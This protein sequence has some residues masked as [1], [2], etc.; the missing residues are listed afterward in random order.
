MSPHEES[1]CNDLQDQF[2]SVYEQEYEING[3][4]VFGDLVNLLVERQEAAIDHNNE[5]NE[6]IEPRV[7]SD[8]LDDLVSKWVRHG[9]AAQRHSGVVLLLVI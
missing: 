2:H 8:K 4:T 3:I 5:K 7:N 9:Q 6:P 1:H